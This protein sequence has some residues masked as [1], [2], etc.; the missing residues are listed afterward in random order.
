M[1]TTSAT[2]KALYAAGAPLEA[3][4]LHLH[5][6]LAGDPRAVHQAGLHVAPTAVRVQ[7]VAGYVQL[8]HILRVVVAVND[9][10]WLYR[11]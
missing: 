7:V 11:C 4:Q 3:Q 1:Q 6:H 2:W 5:L 10:H 9:E 8:L